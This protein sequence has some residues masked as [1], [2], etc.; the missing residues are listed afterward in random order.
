MKH[1]KLFE[2]YD[3]VNEGAVSE[4]RSNID[5][6][7]GDAD[8]D[9][10]SQWTPEQALEWGVGFS[11]EY[12]LW[13]PDDEAKDIVW[14]DK[15]PP[16]LDRA[17]KQMENFCNVVWPKTMDADLDQYTVVMFITNVVQQQ[18]GEYSWIDNPV[19]NKEV[20]AL[21]DVFKTKPE[22]DEAR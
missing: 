6:I 21:N 9:P 5:Q 4:L 3:Q 14:G 20:V 7:E 10:G 19:Y 22:E 2:N 11:K 15:T 18:R 16:D 12:G 17:E 8:M 13:H 1:L